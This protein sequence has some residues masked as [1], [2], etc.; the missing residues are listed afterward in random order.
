MPWH[1]MTCPDLDTVLLGD[2]DKGGFGLQAADPDDIIVLTKQWMFHSHL[3][4]RPL[5]LCPASYASKLHE[6][7]PTSANL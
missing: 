1:D 4:Q 7:G 2:V 5:L 6:S 3:M